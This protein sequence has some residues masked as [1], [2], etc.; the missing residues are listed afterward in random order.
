MGS[1]Y[2]SEGYQSMSAHFEEFLGRSNRFGRLEIS[3]NA[4]KTTELSN[5]NSA[6]GDLRRKIILIEEFPNTILSS[7]NV[8]RAFQSS[9]LEY[10]AVSTPPMGAILSR[11]SVT[12]ITPMVVIITETR[13]T[14]TTAASDNFTAHRLLGSDILSH[15]GVRVIEFNPIAPTLLTKALDLVIQKEARQSGRRR[16]PG[17]SVLKQ[18]GE[19]GDVR[20]AIGS[21]E[22]LCL[23]GGDGNDWGGR[24]ASRTKK[25]SKASSVI[26][27]MEKETLEMVTQ[28][29]SSLGLF[30][31][32]GK[33][34]YNK[35]DDVTEPVEQPP[36]H[37]P[38]YV[39]QRVSQVSTDSL[40]DETG[41]D[42]ETFVAA[43]HENFV[44]SCEGVS[45]MDSIN[46]CLGHLSDS[47]ILGSPRSGRYGSSGQY[48][49]RSFQGAGSDSLRQ[50]EMCFQL[51]VRGLL[52]S[53]PDP[54]KRT[55][56]PTASKG[57][58]K[59]DSHKM[60]YPTSMR[61]S[62]QTEEID[63]LI[64]R[65]TDHLRAGTILMRQLSTESAYL[66]APAMSDR[67]KS[68]HNKCE[69]SAEQLDQEESEQVRMNLNATKPELVLERLPYI[70]IIEKHNPASL[71]RPDLEK[72]TQFQG[73]GIL[74]TEASEDDV[75]NEVLET[76]WTTDRPAVVN[77]QGQS[78][79]HGLKETASIVLPE[80]DEAEKL[81][82]SD[83]DIED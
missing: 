78:V 48:G 18:L 5:G 15:P 23:R 81:Y 61:L 29:E 13:L 46:D 43:L 7:S 21:L 12:D 63:S 71:T 66:A 58:E 27:K 42:T 76:E 40:I 79:R 77:F 38:E 31:A 50:D 72:I 6:R 36:N 34:V 10:L 9:V 26:T 35:R 51:A 32:V 49:S 55:A 2:L 62:R 33:V 47:D 74:N 8:L 24:V 65:W 59:R 19:V 64:S 70:A 22:F 44:L 16:I 11:A 56:H 4:G 80:K 3:E 20:S 83:D 60:F 54:V 69:V 14:T 1:E 73:I 37:L 82:L 57:G 45:F 39:R 52:F 53:L 28:R 75:D 68:P 41:T 67:W 30:H 17:P 25:G